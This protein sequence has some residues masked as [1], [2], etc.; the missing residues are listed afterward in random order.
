[1]NRSRRTP[2]IK[3]FV[4]GGVY[5]PSKQQPSVAA[6]THSPVTPRNYS[7]QNTPKR[8]LTKP[9][10]QEGKDAQQP[11][12][13][14]LQEAEAVN[15]SE[16]LPDTVDDDVVEVNVPE[17]VAQEKEYVLKKSEIDESEPM[18]DNN[19]EEG[20]TAKKKNKILFKKIFANRKKSSVRAKEK[21][22][23]QNRQMRK[24][25]LP[26]NALMALNE[27]KG[28]DISDF[29]VNSN[30][31]GG[32][33]AIVSVN[34]IQY[35]GKGSS[36]IVAKNNACEK[37]LRDYVLAKMRQKPRRG[38]HVS[39]IET[40]M[41]TTEENGNEE[42]DAES[43]IGESQK[44]YSDEADDVPMINLTS[45]AL[46]KLFSSWESE[47]YEIPE[48]H[49]SQSSNESDSAPKEPKKPPIR[50]ELPENWDTMH[51]AT[52]LCIMRP[53]LTYTNYGVTGNKPNTIQSL[54]VVVEGQ[55]FIGK[56]RSKKVARRNTAAAVCNGLFDT[57]FEIEDLAPNAAPTPV[58]S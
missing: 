34:D 55:E 33:T 18:D 38:N 20:N 21:K 14:K 39:S 9:F 6:A 26:K 27:I 7:Y 25:L 36:K 41:D 40:S 53:G 13:T 8:T 37:A 50:N 16:P 58:V 35:E 54:G 29:V 4:Q 32:F 56:G 3:P 30:V 44:L 28:I 15:Q 43:N 12:Q 42:N 1:M 31:G 22:I 2:Q 51:P 49:P 57:N 19:D 47:G 17:E 10:Q 23:R 11:N 24:V 46:Y 45:F 5:D 48:F 52:L